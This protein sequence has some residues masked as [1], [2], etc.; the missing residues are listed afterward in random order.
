[1]CQSVCLCVCACMCVYVCV[2]EGGSVAVRYGMG[3]EKGLLKEPQKMQDTPFLWEFQYLTHN[4]KLMM[5]TQK[6]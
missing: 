6:L 5:M 1:M 2:W 4:L 3:K